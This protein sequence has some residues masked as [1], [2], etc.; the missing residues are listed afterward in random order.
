M[1]NIRLTLQY[2]GTRYLG[3]QRPAKSGAQKSISHKITEV[4]RKATGE[5]IM[6]RA[7][8]KTEPGVHALAQ[9]VSFETESLLSAG[10]FRSLLNRY[11]PADIAV[12]DA[13]AA[14]ERFRADLNALSRTYEYRICCS[15]IYDVFRAKYEAHLCPG[16][17][18]SAMEAAAG[19]L[20][21]RHDFR[22]FSDARKKAA[23]EKEITDISFCSLD[24]HLAIRITADDFLSRM[25]RNIIGTLLDAGYHRLAPEDIPGL[26]YGEL[27]LRKPAVPGKQASPEQR[28][29]PGKQTSPEERAPGKQ[30]G[31]LFTPKA[32]LLTDIQYP[33][34]IS[35]TI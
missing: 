33:Q 18:I 8:A 4:L 25:P 5:A 13:A 3:W 6:L 1:Q 16:P 24:G 20:R 23:T 14:P 2:D 12:L 15:R 21:G 27:P 30:T 22:A 28:T 19:Y 35:P 17:D 26:F 7:G 29:A 10:E 34:N 32:L 11:L 31:E 9:T